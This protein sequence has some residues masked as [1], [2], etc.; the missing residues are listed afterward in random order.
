M[1]PAKTKQAAY[2]KSAVIIMLH[3]AFYAMLPT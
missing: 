1:Q 3:H 2:V